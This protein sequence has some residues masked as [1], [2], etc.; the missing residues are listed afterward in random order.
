[1]R[2][3]VG[4]AEKKKGGFTRELQLKTA[5][6][7]GSKPILDRR[8]H[9]LSVFLSR[10]IGLDFIFFCIF[11]CV[12]KTRV[13]LD[14]SHICLLYCYICIFFF[15]PLV[16]SLFEQGVEFLSPRLASNTSRRG[17]SAILFYSWA[18]SKRV[19]KDNFHPLLWLS[20]SPSFKVLSQLYFLFLGA[21]FIPRRKFKPNL[22]TRG[23]TL[24]LS[25]TAS[26]PRWDAVF[27]LQGKSGESTFS[28]RI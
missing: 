26:L 4:H 12:L 20:F 13:C 8:G 3:P 27:T 11:F 2:T 7:N 6:G 21:A 28:Q 9:T 17:S 1:M 18:N 16:A 25:L 10:L 15:S 5:K 24:S 23:F 19:I 22:Q 14:W